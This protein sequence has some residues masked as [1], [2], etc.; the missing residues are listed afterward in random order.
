MAYIGMGHNIDNLKPELNKGY[1]FVEKPM[2]SSRLWAA[3]Q[4]MPSE[5]RIGKPLR[6]QATVAGSIVHGGRVLIPK[7]N[8]ATKKF[9]VVNPSGLTLPRRSDDDIETPR[10]HNN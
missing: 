8:G 1:A 3:K 4:H 6:K 2:R 5:A 9:R 10:L 7:G